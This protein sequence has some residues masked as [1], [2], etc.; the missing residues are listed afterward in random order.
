MSRRLGFSSPGFRNGRTPSAPTGSLPASAS[1]GRSG[2]PRDRVADAPDS[3]LARVRGVTRRRSPADKS[4][5][6]KAVPNIPD[7]CL[8]QHAERVLELSRASGQDV[9]ACQ[10]LARSER[11]DTAIRRHPARGVRRVSPTTR[12]RAGSHV[13]GAH[14]V[15]LRVHT[16]LQLG[17]RRRARRA[18]YACC[19]SPTNAASMGIG[20]SRER[21][22]RVDHRLRA[23]R[24]ARPGGHRNSARQRL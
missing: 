10:A 23:G 19:G 5:P 9:R 22:Q 15:R 12:E 8:S 21:R 24:P 20:M 4:E 3:S 7:R 18:G 13:A 14:R 6:D 16:W 2:S 17:D 11:V 1:P